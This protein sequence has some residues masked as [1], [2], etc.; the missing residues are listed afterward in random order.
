VGLVWSDWRCGGLGFKEAIHDFWC[1]FNTY[2]GGH[3]R[4]WVVIL[5]GV[6]SPMPIFSLVQTR[7]PLVLWLLFPVAVSYD[8]FCLRL[9]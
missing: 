4:S 6:V 2:T 7:K 8:V 3:R 1:G 5:S 9:V